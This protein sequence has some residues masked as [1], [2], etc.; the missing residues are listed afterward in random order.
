MPTPSTLA[1][2][3]G[4]SRGLGLALAEQL[5]HESQVLLTVARQTPPQTLSDLAQTNHCQHF[6][7]SVDFSDMASVDDIRHRITPWLEK[8]FDQYLLINNAGTLGPVA[9]YHG[10]SQTSSQTI[11][12]TFDINIATVIAISSTFLATVRTHQKATI[13]I[14]NISSGAAR[15]AYA[16]WAAYCA[17]KAALDR[18][19]EVAQLEAPFAQIVSLAP[20]VVDTTMQGEIRA[21]NLEDFPPLQRFKDLHAHQALSSPTEVAKKIL[22]YRLHPDFGKQTLSDIRLM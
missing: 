18:Y 12:N 20:G 22:A 9:Q 8:P 6:H 14:I 17:S 10:L 16:G 7:F 3:T 13:Q 5:T 4:A 19:S 1:I 11:A 2:V 21:S 15:S